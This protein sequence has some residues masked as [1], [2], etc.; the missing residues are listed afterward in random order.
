MTSRIAFLCHSDPLGLEDMNDQGG[1]ENIQ[2]AKLAI[3][4]RVPYVRKRTGGD[5][6]YTY[7]A[8][9]DFV[10]RVRPVLV[11]CDVTLAP[12]KSRVVDSTPLVTSRGTPMVSRCIEVTYR[13]THVP[14]GTHEDVEVVGE[15]CDTLDKAS[16]KAMTQ[17]LKYAIRQWLFIE[18]GDDP[19]KIQEVDAMQLTASA[20][21]AN[22]K[23]R[24]S[25][26]KAELNKI[27]RRLA[28]SDNIGSAERGFLSESLQA[29]RDEMLSLDDL[30]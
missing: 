23:I 17:A 1:L 20:R 28:A 21:A 25:T 6:K 24:S 19:D 16:S 4:K 13:F 8:E 22:D 7:A 14:S 30:E 10:R 15:A 11:S 3:M 27:E 26:T 2:Q 5:L 12:V 9:A 18:T 29:K